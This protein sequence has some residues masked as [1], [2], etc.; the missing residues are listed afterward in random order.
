MIMFCAAIEWGVAI[1]DLVL[2]GYS[3]RPQVVGE[4]ITNIPHT[5]LIRI[6]GIEITGKVGENDS[7]DTEI[8][9]YVKKGKEWVDAHHR[10]N[11]HFVLPSVL[12]T[13]TDRIRILAGYYGKQPYSKPC[14]KQF[15]FNC[16]LKNP[17]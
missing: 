13:P 7:L 1:P 6:Y 16:T 17:G 5:G 14:I 11:N 4:L 15:N 10:G 3:I 9:T 2:E 12:I 8:V